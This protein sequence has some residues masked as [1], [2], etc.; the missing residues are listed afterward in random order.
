MQSKLYMHHKLVINLR[1]VR[2]MDK[3]MYI[4]QFTCTCTCIMGYYTTLKEHFKYF[5]I[6]L[7]CM[8]SSIPSSLSDPST[9]KTKYNVA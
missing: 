1:S 7:T 6:I 3:Y 4:Y 5:Q 2:W 8:R 9:Q